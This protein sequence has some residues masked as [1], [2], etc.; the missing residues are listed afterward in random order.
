MLSIDYKFVLKITNKRPLSEAFDTSYH[1]KRCLLQVGVLI[2]E[3]F[4]ML[5]LDELCNLVHSSIQ[6][7]MV[8]E[9]TIRAKLKAKRGSHCNHSPNGWPPS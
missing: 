9:K 8:N 2:E 6:E 3:P 7:A 5:A 1:D 4:S